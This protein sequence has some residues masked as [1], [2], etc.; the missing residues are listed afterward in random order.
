MTKRPSS[1]TVTAIVCGRSHVGPYSERFAKTV[2]RLR[3]GRHRVAALP[4][5]CRPQGV[6]LP[7]T[8][9]GSTTPEGGK[10]AMGPPNPSGAE[11]EVEIMASIPPRICRVTRRW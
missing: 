3:F 4:H 11:R 8:R 9:V 5:D 10:P 7:P 6:P 2:K 1:V